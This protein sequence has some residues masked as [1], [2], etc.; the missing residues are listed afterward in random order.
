MDLRPATIEDARLLFEWRNDPSTRTQMHST[1]DFDF[2]SHLAWLERTLSNPARKLY[3]AEV[4]GCPVGTVRADAAD[5]ITELSWTVAPQARGRGLGTQMVQAFIA[6]L[7]GPLRAEVKTGNI[8]SRKIAE[9]IG[10]RLES[11]RDGLL[12][13]ISSARPRSLARAVPS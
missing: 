3:V 10:L 13:F 5:G 2:P 7:D 6:T 8:A 9:S 4:E 12:T 11:E 1:G